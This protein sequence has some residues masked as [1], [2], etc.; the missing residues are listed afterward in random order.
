[1]I[2]PSLGRLTREEVAEMVRRAAPD[3]PVERVAVLRQLPDLL[4]VEVDGE[5][6]FRFAGSRDVVG[7]LAAEHRLLAAIGDRVSAALPQPTRSAPDLSWDAYGRIEG[8]LLGAR[9]VDESLTEDDWRRVA[10]GVGT[11]LAELHDAIDLES[12]VALELPPTFFPPSEL[13]L[14]GRTLPLMESEEERELVRRVHRLLREVTPRLVRP[15]LIHGD[16]HGDNL[17]VGADGSLVG[18]LDFRTALIADRHLD[19]RCLFGYGEIM[20]GAVEAY[21]RRSS[22]PVD[23]RSCQVISAANHLQDMTWRAEQGM[24]TRPIPVRVSDLRERLR[25]RGLL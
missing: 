24:P 14:L 7:Q 3:L 12:A 23:L 17:L 4:V 1:M 6:I 15:T 21:N 25:T 22:I 5:Y 10:A 2:E 19:F 11:F 8:D 20:E 16:L 13:D 9:S 18:V